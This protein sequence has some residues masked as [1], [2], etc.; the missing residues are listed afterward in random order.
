M[1]I[2]LFQMKGNLPCPNATG[3]FKSPVMFV[4]LS[5]SDWS[6]SLIT[7]DLQA[8]EVLRCLECFQDSPRPVYPASGPIVHSIQSLFPNLPNKSLP[9][10]SSFSTIVVISTFQVRIPKLTDLLQPEAYALVNVKLQT[11]YIKLMFKN[12]EIPFI[13]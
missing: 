10:S 1:K 11:D 3:L 13:S 2:L 8:A 7:N 6:W 9:V 4:F 12:T 5:I